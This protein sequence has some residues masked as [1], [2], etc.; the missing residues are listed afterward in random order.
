MIYIWSPVN[1]Q[2]LKIGMQLMISLINWTF[3][4]E[5][6]FHIASFVQPTD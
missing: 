3:I 2:H 4:L 1:E 5:K 6:N